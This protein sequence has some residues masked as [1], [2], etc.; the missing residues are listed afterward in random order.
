[1]RIIEKEK[2]GETYRKKIDQEERERERD[3]GGQTLLTSYIK[4]PL[5]ELEIG[6]KI[7]LNVIIIIFGVNYSW[8]E[9]LVVL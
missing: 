5:G 3:I 1:M 7:Q 4:Q 9:R 8:F 6:Y 2:G